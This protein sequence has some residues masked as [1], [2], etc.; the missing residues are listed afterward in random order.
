MEQ[1]EETVPNIM[2]KS[3]S[4]PLGLEELYRVGNKDKTYGRYALGRARGR[5]EVGQ[6]R[7]EAAEPAKPG[8][9]PQP[10]EPGSSLWLGSYFPS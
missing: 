9:G 5:T 4:F 3:C 6:D 10:A 8:Q 1:V 7:G 2:L